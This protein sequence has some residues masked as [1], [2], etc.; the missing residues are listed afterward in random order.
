MKR[1]SLA[2]PGL[3]ASGDDDVER[4]CG[5]S[6]IVKVGVSAMLVG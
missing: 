3:Q 6:R 1:K 5:S 4:G 2:W